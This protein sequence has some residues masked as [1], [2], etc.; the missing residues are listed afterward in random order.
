MNKLLQTNQK[1]IA[2]F[3]G[4]VIGCAIFMT[5]YGFDILNG[6]NVDW[7]LRAGGDLTQSYYG[8]CF[9]RASPAFSLTLF[10]FL[11]YGG[12]FVLSYLVR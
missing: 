5:I 3:V 7:I 9:F 10:N 1:Q 8:W 11:V 12:W 6:T 2:A 4:G